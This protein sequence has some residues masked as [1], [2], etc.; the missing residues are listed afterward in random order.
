[1]Y[2]RTLSLSA[3]VAFAAAGAGC[4]STH[5]GDPKD[6]ETV[7][8]D[9][10]STD[11]Q[12]MTAKMTESL[13]N[14]PNLAYFDRPN[15]GDDKR[16][17]L[18]M[19][20]VQNST[21]EHI[22]TGAVTDVI[23]TDLFKT[24]RFKFVADKPAQEEIGEQVNYQQGS[25]RFDP[26]RAMAFGKQI[27]AEV[28]VEG[29]L[30]SIEKKKGRSLESGGSKFEDTYYLLVLNAWNVETGELMWSETGEIRKQQRTGLFG[31]A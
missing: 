21:S 5:Y 4:S 2:L 8:I 22:D 6:T 27:G 1:M 15:K 12:T 13:K 31:G 11:I 25:G 24:G 26:S 28:I 17:I 23:R 20:K 29:N 16:V 10:G 7:N 3:L 9:W 18:Y 19:G 30:R 14:S